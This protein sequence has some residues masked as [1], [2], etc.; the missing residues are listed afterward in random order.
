MTPEMRGAWLDRLADERDSVDLCARCPSVDDL[1]PAGDAADALDCAPEV[2]LCGRC[3]RGEPV[4]PLAPEPFD[5]EA[6]L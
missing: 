1:A 6:P 3:R 2:I 4:A 5:P